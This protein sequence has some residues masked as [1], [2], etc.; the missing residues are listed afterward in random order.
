[1]LYHDVTL[2][3][4]PQSKKNANMHE[5]V[6]HKTLYDDELILRITKAWILQWCINANESV[7]VYT[8][9][10]ALEQRTKIKLFL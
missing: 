8:L 7:S 3:H 9:Q 4:N 5:T 10:A 2:I 6:N 1:M